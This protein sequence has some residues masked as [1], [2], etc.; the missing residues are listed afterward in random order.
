MSDPIDRALLAGLV[1]FIVGGI[2]GG[3]VLVGLA[4]GLWAVPIWLL[5]VEDLLLRS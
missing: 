4:A 5:V 3:S 1:S 2:V